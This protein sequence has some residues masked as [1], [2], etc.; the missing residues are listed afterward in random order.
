MIRYPFALL[1]AGLCCASI[2]LAADEGAYG[3]DIHTQSTVTNDAAVRHVDSTDVQ[4]VPSVSTVQG[5]PV[6]QDV[7]RTEPVQRETSPTVCSGKAD[8]SGPVPFADIGTIGAGATLDSAK[9]D[10]QD[11]RVAVCGEIINDDLVL[12]MPAGTIRD[13]LSMRNDSGLDIRRAELMR[14][15][16]WDGDDLH[17]RLADIGLDRNSGLGNLWV[18]GTGPESSSLLQRVAISGVQSQPI[19]QQEPIQQQAQQQPLNEPN[20]MSEQQRNLERSRNMSA[21]S[22]TDESDAF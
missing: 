13:T 19:A 22:R 1:L 17:V 7:A 8:R 10:E 4:R 2:A 6:Q 3:S 11:R 15:S 16:R 21:S 18:W 20:M 9:A 12:H 5:A 14:I